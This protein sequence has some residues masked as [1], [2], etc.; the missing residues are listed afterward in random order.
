MIRD[1][2][3]RPQV[4]QSMLDVVS[5]SGYAAELSDFTSPFSVRSL[6]RSVRSRKTVTDNGWVPLKPLRASG[7]QSPL[8]LIHDFAGNSKV[9]ESLAAALGDDQPCYAITSRGLADPVACHQSVEE[10]ADA[11]VEAILALDPEGPHGLVG[12]GFGGLIAFEMARRLEEFGTSPRF[13]ALLRT[14][15]PVA[16]VARRGLR[17]VSQGFFKTLRGW[18]GSGPAAVGGDPN[19]RKTG[20]NPVLESNREAAAKYTPNGVSRFEMHVFTPEKDF[21]PFKDVQAGW[22]A[23]C[24]EVNYYQVP[25]SASELLDEP[26]VSAVGTALAKLA[27][28]QELEDD[29]D[30]ISEDSL[31]K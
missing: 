5:Q 25:C 9:C 13:I 7:S 21:P 31:E 19:R 24:S 22:N 20:P 11:Y 28:Y 30:V 23:F 17:A 12:I 26:A 6:L 2:K 3:L 16:S 1:G 27:R 14:E 15:P 8:I 18:S 29:A 10:M 4:A